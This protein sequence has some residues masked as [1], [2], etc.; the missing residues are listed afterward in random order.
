MSL[1]SLRSRSNL[2]FVSF[3]LK[4]SLN[5]SSVNARIWGDGNMTEEIRGKIAD[6]N[7]LYQETFDATKES[8]TTYVNNSYTFFF[9]GK[10]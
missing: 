2:T 7:V 5:F 9:E 10:H 8:V 3:Y 1:I 4:K 6:I